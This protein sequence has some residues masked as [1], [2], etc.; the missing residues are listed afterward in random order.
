MS[1]PSCQV[2]KLM[3]PLMMTNDPTICVVRMWTPRGAATVS[4]NPTPVRR[5]GRHVVGSRSSRGC[6]KVRNSS[7]YVL[8]HP[9]VT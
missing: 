4:R 7:P 5:A 9:Q 3:M 8:K 2:I 6:E 1:S